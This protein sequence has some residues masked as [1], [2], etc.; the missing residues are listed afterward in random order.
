MDTLRKTRKKTD[1]NVQRT[2]THQAMQPPPKREDSRGMGPALMS[3]L[4]STWGENWNG[5]VEKHEISV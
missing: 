4:N 1:S 5:S 2:L 3:G